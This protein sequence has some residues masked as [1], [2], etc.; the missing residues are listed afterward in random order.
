MT[1]WNAAAWRASFLAVGGTLT[2]HDGELIVGWRLDDPAQD[3][4]AADV[5]SDIRGNSARFAIIRSMV[6]AGNRISASAPRF[7]ASAWLQS[8]TE[9][10]GGYA[11][12][13]DNRVSFVVRECPAD[14]LVGVM[15]QIVGFPDRQD[16]VRAA[17]ERRQNGDLP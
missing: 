14:G 8:L 9:I 4:A 2:L 13:G 7:D 16:A 3:R 17:I 12:G 11:L 5:F 10:G 15:E 6:E 1:A